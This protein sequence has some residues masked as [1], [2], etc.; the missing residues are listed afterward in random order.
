MKLPVHRENECQQL[1]KKAEDWNT[2]EKA[3]RSESESSPVAKEVWQQTAC[4]E[5]V[6]LGGTAPDKKCE[7]DTQPCGCPPSLGLMAPFPQPP[8]GLQLGRKTTGVREGHVRR[9]EGGRTKDMTRKTPI[10]LFSFF[11]SIF[12]FINYRG[13]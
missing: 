1:H 12:S 2:H 11:Q 13:T 10:S 3:C 5:C 6:S 4:R 7:C 9:V 8:L